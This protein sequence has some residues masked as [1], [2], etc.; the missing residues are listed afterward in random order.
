MVAAVMGVAAMGA[1]TEAAVTA[2]LAME[3]EAK[4]TV[5]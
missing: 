1:A 3:A 2:G 4:V 5:W